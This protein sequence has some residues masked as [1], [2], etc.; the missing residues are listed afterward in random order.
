[1]SE[2]KASAV[3]KSESS[4]LITSNMVFYILGL[5]KSEQSIYLPS[6]SFLFQHI[7]HF[8]RQHQ[9]TPIIPFI[10]IDQH[11]RRLLRH[12]FLNKMPCFRKDLQLV[13]SYVSDVSYH[14]TNESPNGKPS[15][16]PCICP[17]ISSLSSRSVPAS[18]NSFPPFASRNF[19]LRPTNQSCQKGCVAARSVRQTQA[20]A[21]FEAF[22]SWRSREGTETRA[23]VVLRMVR[24]RMLGG[25]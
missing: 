18:S 22:G 19:L 7:A 1:M 12:I 6:L 23:E 16:I 8:R 10:E 25:K 5:S 9:R 4:L 17:I 2:M 13:L 3:I 24:D 14:P 11:H 21:A 20:F 15:Y